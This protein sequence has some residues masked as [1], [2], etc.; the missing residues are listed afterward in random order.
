MYGMVFIH[1]GKDL[2]ERWYG[3]EVWCWVNGVKCQRIQKIKKRDVSGQYQTRNPRHKKCSYLLWK[4]SLK[5]RLLSFI[6]K[7]KISS[8]LCKQCVLFLHGWSKKKNS[9]YRINK[10][11]S[12]FCSTKPWLWPNDKDIKSSVSSEN[13]CFQADSILFERTTEE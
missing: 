4:R 7:P 1:E 9:L 10:D 11:D 2:A 5:Q 12:C 13:V 6:L 8:V 3:K